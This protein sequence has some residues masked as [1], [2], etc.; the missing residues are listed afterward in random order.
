MPVINTAFGYYLTWHRCTRLHGVQKKHVAMEMCQMVGAPPPALVSAAHTAASFSPRRC[1]QLQFH[2]H[3][4]VGTC[5]SSPAAR[6]PLPQAA[7]VPRQPPPC[8]PSNV[9]S[10][11]AALSAPSPSSQSHAPPGCCS[12]G[13]PAPLAP[14]PVPVPPPAGLHAPP[15]VRKHRQ[16]VTLGHSNSRGCRSPTARTLQRACP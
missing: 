15:S 1:L 9:T 8:A 3:C 16:S 4:N 11:P 10:A 6:A 14:R 13:L 12:R 7:A 5:S 2:R